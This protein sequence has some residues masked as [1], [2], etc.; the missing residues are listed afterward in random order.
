MTKPLKYLC[1]FHRKQHLEEDYIKFDT[2]SNEDQEEDE[3]LVF[4]N[5]DSFERIEYDVQQHKGI[6]RPV[7]RVKK[8]TQKR[9]RVF[10]EQVIKSKVQLNAD[11][12][13]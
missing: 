11:E 13:K 12:Q 7:K 10:T 5:G 2:S 3:D 4:V 6:F 1:D 9:K 8:V